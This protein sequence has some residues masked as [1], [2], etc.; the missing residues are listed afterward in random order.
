MFWQGKNLSKGNFWPLSQGSAQDCRLAVPGS[1]P[2]HF[3]PDPDP[4]NQNVK[5]RIR[6]LLALAKKEFKTSQFFFHINQISSDIWMLIFF[7]LKMYNFTWKCVKALF[8]PLIHTTLHRIRIR[9]KM[10]GFDRIRHPATK[11]IEQKWRIYLNLGCWRPG[12]ICCSIHL[13]H[14]HFDF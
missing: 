13:L 4:A 1:N 14:L 8:F 5:N 12:N 10:S 9:P 7:F 2:V 11:N 3:R 6:I